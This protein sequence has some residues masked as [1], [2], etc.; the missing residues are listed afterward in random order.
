MFNYLDNW[1]ASKHTYDYDKFIIIEELIDNDDLRANIE[2]EYDGEDGRLWFDS[3]F[4]KYLMD[5][6][7]KTTEEI[8]HLV[9]EW[10]ESKFG[11][12]VK[13]IN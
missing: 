5:I 6:S 2:M 10:F 3:D 7:N 4:R 12:E 1:L 9:K 13:N 8:N 11:V